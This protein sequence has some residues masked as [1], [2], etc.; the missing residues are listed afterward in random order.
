MQE[1]SLYDMVFH[2]WNTIRCFLYSTFLVTNE[3]QLE[4]KFTLCSL[5][6][7]NYGSTNFL[8]SLDL[9]ILPHIWYLF[10][11]DILSV[12]FPAFAPHNGMMWWNVEIIIC[13]KWL[14]PFYCM[15]VPKRVWTDVVLVVVYL[16]NRMPSSVL[17]GA[18]ITKQSESWPMLTLRTSA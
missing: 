9:L 5:T 4:P 3:N 12:K 2:L 18:S 14:E 1:H 8:I 7:S 13:R 11:N 10:E 17:D 16:I 15:C 6:I